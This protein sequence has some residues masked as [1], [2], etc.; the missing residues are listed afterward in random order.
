MTAFPL[1]SS[2][3]TVGS[4][5]LKNRVVMGSMHTGHEGHPGG[6]EKLAAFYRARARGGAALIVTGGWSPTT[7]GNLK[8]H[9][10]E[11]TTEADAADHRVIPDAV[12]EEGGRIVLQLLHA[13]RYAYRKDAVAPSEVPCP[14]NPFPA[15]SLTAEEIEATIEA[16]AAS[17]ALARQSGYDGV[18]IMGSEGYLLTQFLCPRTNRRE[19]EWGGS[20]VA[21]MRFPLAVVTAV[22]AAL[23]PEGLLLYRISAAD[24][25][26]GGLDADEVIAVAKA[27]EEAGADALTTGIGWHESRVPTIAQAVPRGAFAWASKRLKQAVSIPVIASNRINAPEIAEQILADSRADLV[28]VARGMLADPEFAAKSVAGDRDGLNIC[29]A[30][31]QACLDHYFI[32][33]PA[34]CLVNPRAGRETTLVLT[35]VET[36]RSIAVIGAGPGGLA[37][38]DALA[39]RGH[40]VTLFERGAELGGQ[41]NLAKHV[42]GKTEFQET[43][44]YFKTRLERFGVTIRLETAAT[45]RGLKAEGYDAVV[46]ATGVVPRVPEIEGIDH[47]SVISYADALTGAKPVGERV[48]VIGAGGIG[49]DVSL[50]LLDEEEAC[51]D[52]AAFV[53]H[54]GVDSA[55]ET[56]GGIVKAPKNKPRREITMLQRKSGGFGKTLGRTTGWIHRAE[57]KRARTQMIGDVTYRRIDDEGVHI[58]VGAE[59]KAEDVTLLCDTVVLCA[60]QD[61]ENGLVAALQA[62]GVE[63]HAI[64]GAKLAAELDAKRAIREA[65]ELAAA[66]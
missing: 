60:G 30:C 44:T 59:G 16:F 35:P 25:V 57:L 61:S 40:R 65:V 13:G 2:P 46:V 34:S 12:H 33:E 58:T 8:E 39:E 51:L 36:P 63:A 43:L 4:V 45:A 9:R 11:M 1:L 42:P 10:C 54:W 21:R 5:T 15:R 3:L 32:E 64:G 14:I 66:L 29:I 37:A 56:P 52:P 18:E 38:A 53:H 20:L 26:E 28:S 6:F 19:D 7:E 23:G 31:N 48:V 27:V 50:F 49:F 55:L 47:P 22:R 17:A 24:L 41:F 62:E